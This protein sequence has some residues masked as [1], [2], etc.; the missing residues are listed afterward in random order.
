M[1]SQ[2]PTP[3]VGGNPSHPPSE[4]AL[5]SDHIYMFNGIDLTTCTTMYDMSDKPNKD[6]VTNGTPPDPYPST[7]SPPS[8]SLQIEKPTFDSILR[9]PK[10]TI[11][12]S[13]FNPSS[14]GAQNYKI[15]VDLAQAPCSMSSLEVIQHF[16]SQRRTLLDTIVQLILSRQIISCLTLITLSHDFLTNLLFKLM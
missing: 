5:L 4:E 1:V 11:H 9:P 2:S 7:V 6:K 12:K 14:C 13:N 8:G 3:L 10:S 15:V 16:P